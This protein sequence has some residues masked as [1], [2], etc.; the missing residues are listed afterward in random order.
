MQNEISDRL[1]VIAKVH[2]AFYRYDLLFFGIN[3][4]V[5][6]YCLVQALT[7]LTSDED[8]DARLVIKYLQQCRGSNLC[9]C[10]CVH[11]SAECK[12][13]VAQ[14][15]Y[16]AFSMIGTHVGKSRLAAKCCLKDSAYAKFMRGH[17]A[18]GIV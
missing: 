7:A 15:E 11:G 3:S 4:D 14:R 2:G 5:G 9:G 10:T 17:Y 1:K 12:A 16:F 8:T 18:L 13:A 6:E